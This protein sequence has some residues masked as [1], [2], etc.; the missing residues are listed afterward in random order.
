[1]GIDRLTEADITG[2]AAGGDSASKSQVGTAYFDN[3]IVRDG[4]RGD[5]N[6]NGVVDAAD[7]TVWRDQLGQ[8]TFGLAA[9]GNADGV[10]DGADYLLWTETFGDTNALASVAIGVPEP[11]WLSDRHFSCAGFLSP[12]PTGF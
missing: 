2:F 6:D 3:F 7:Y 5:Y 4:L 8:T 9:D 10:V 12:F 1:M 11:Q